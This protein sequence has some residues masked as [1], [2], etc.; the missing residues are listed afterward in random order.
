ME[1]FMRSDLAAE[2]GARTGAKGISVHT[3]DAEGCEILR[4]QIKTPEASAALGKPVGRYVTLDCGDICVLHTVEEERVRRALAVELRDM[5]ERLCGR[6][7]GV[8]F[9]LLVAGLG[10]E[11]LTPDALGAQTVQRLTVT[12]QCAAEERELCTTGV[13]SAVAP[14]ISAQTGLK[15]SEFLAGI[16]SVVHPDL[17]VAVDALAARSPDRLGHTVQLCDTGIRPGS[18]IGRGGRELTEETLGVPVLALGIPT[19]IDTATLVADA[20]VGVKYGE[21]SP[22]MQESLERA[23]GYFVAPR[24]IDLLVSRGAA[25]LAAALEKAFSQGE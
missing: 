22:E 24:E 16:V 19:V 11:M 8:G 4:V 12:R 14:G 3:A 5:A 9:S 13:I 1:R 10:N 2:C 7:I 18:G 20:L 6:R 23:R 15:T 17:V 25:L 21:L